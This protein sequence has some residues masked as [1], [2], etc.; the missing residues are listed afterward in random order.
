MGAKHVL[1]L[2]SI[3]AASDS[4]RVERSAKRDLSDYRAFRDVT[5]LPYHVPGKTRM[6][7]F[8][9]RVEE[10]LL[11]L[12]NCPSRNVSV[13][14]KAGSF[15]VV[16]PDGAKFPPDYRLSEAT[17]QYEMTMLSD[18]RF[19]SL[20]VSNPAAGDWYAV[21]YLS[22]TDPN[23]DRIVQQGI[24][25][26]C[27]A[28][29][30]STLDV[31][32]A[33]EEDIVIINNAHSEILNVSKNSVLVKE[34][35]FFV[36]W[37]TG[38][39]SLNLTFQQCAPDCPTVNMAV[40]PNGF[41]TTDDPTDNKTIHLTCTSEQIV[42]GDLC[43]IQFGPSEGTWHYV[44]LSVEYNSTKFKSLAGRYVSFTVSVD[45]MPFSCVHDG[46]F[47]NSRNNCNYNQSS[48]SDE[49]CYSHCIWWKVPL[50]RQSY[51]P[52][53]MYNYVRLPDE[54]GKSS[55]SL[56]IS[57]DTPT[58]MSFPV[59]PVK[60]IGG[61]LTVQLQVE[62][63]VKTK[64]MTT[65]L[66][67]ISLVACLSHELR[68]TPSFDST[69]VNAA[70]KRTL[71]AVS[72]NSTSTKR[73]QGKIHVPYPEEGSWYLTI[74]IFCFTKDEITCSGLNY[75][76]VSFVI[77]SEACGPEMCGNFG[78]CNSYQSG[79][80][81]FSSCEC[82]HGYR[83]WGCTDDSAITPIG[84]LLV[85]ALLLTL[86]NLFFLVTV[87]MAFRER[88]YTET[89]VYGC[90]MFFSTFYHACDAGEGVYSFCMMPL[91]VLQFCD[92][93]SAILAVWVTL[94]AMANL[95][96]PCRSFLHMG[97]AVGIALGTELDRT[98][99]AVFLVPALV[100]LLIL[101][102]RW[103]ARCRQRRSWYPTVEYWHW[104]APLGLI[105]V[106]VGL[107]SYA[108][109]QTRTNYKYV[110]SLWHSVMALSVVFLL[111]SRK[112]FGEGDTPKPLW[113]PI[114]QWWRERRLNR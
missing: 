4:T 56:N 86:S 103:A 46:L 88:Y 2:L 27:N 108:F 80:V 40:R 91:Y 31:E 38:E 44:S 111:P 55:Y 75:T 59:Y 90:T 25:T 51:V 15:P 23:D 24:N 101:G 79:A 60:D 98:S 72:M 76:T 106:V 62:M 93:Y 100:G 63:D 21:V 82:F 18:G 28:L 49:M 42:D 10:I 50:M 52:F 102:A 64:I 114:Q 110:H 26:A 66:F 37:G 112:F 104:R 33:N 32:A 47:F 3:A 17:Y 83:G 48:S 67:N 14:L 16:N 71:A 77:D 69:C 19:V 20:N 92:F 94:V 109:L 85:A 74:K 39:V 54:N 68:A 84:E 70:G 107:I 89:L 96:S 36:P 6:A 53:F 45:L 61:T 12:G 41:P 29:V 30:E 81:I 34:Y 11:T 65:T 97:G 1:L 95:P 87:L 8:A 105:L 57:T 99:L 5:V 13:A 113:M 73:M 7:S 78:R 9:F 58:L 43:S 35:S 22:Y